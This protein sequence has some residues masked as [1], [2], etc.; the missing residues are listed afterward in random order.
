MFCRAKIS[1]LLPL[2]GALTASGA[3]LNPEQRNTAFQPGGNSGNI[4]TAVRRPSEVAVHRK[5]WSGAKVQ[6]ITPRSQ[7][8]VRTELT[9][10]SFAKAG[11]APVSPGTVQKAGGGR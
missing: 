2:V 7:A 4:P 5:P 9:G 10:V 11:D 6:L 1:V 8:L 3:L